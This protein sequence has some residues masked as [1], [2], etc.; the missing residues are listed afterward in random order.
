MGKDKA[1]SDKQKMFDTG[2]PKKGAAG[3]GKSKGKVK[4]KK[5]GK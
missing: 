3:Q 2:N 1:K 4:G 5:K